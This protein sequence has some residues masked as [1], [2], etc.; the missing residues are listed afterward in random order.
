M[1]MA[2]EILELVSENR[3]L[4]SAVKR[5]E[6]NYDREKHLVQEVCKFGETIDPDFRSKCA[7]AVD[8]WKASGSTWDFTKIVSRSLEDPKGIK[9]GDDDA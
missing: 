5:L 7:K 6:D 1:S 8:P 2:K 9:Y 4:R 3:N